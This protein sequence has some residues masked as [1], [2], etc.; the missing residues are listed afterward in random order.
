MCLYVKDN[1]K[2]EISEE[3]KTVFKVFVAY[4]TYY[5]ILLNSPYTNHQYNKK[6]NVEENFGVT[7]KKSIAAQG[8][9]K[10]LVTYGFHSFEKYEDALILRNYLERIERQF[11]PASYERTHFLVLACT[12]PKDSKYY[13]GEFPHLAYSKMPVSYCSD[14]LIINDQRVVLR[15]GTVNNILYD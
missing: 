13:I 9:S 14:R 3:E 5:G 2:Y 8:T 7:S 6:Y 4:E 10:N 11:S 12:I 15:N 1:S